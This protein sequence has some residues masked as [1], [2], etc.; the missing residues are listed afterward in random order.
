MRRNELRNLQHI[1]REEEN[2]ARDRNE[3]H[4]ESQEVARLKEEMANMRWRESQ[5]L[6]KDKKSH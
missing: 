3:I 4:K 2:E 1:R 5:E 6:L